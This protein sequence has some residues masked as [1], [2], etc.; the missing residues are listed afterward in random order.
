MLKIIS[1]TVL[2]SFIMASPV[3]AGEDKGFFESAWE[4]VTSYFSDGE[5][6]DKDKKDRHDKSDDH[7]KDDADDGVTPPAPTPAPDTTPPV[8]TP[9]AAVT[10]DSTT[11]K[12]IAVTIGT[13]TA[14]DANGNSATA[15][16]LVTVTD[17]SIFA[18]LPPDP[19][20]AGRATLA[21]IDSDNDGVRDDVQR[22]IVMT[23]PNSAKTRAALRQDAIALQ[24][25]I[26]DSANPTLT[27][28]HALED[29]KATDCL[30]YIR[31]NDFY[32]VVVDLEAVVVNTPQRSRAY[33]RADQLM[34]GK[35][36][37]SPPNRKQGC[38]FNPDVMPN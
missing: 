21:G 14:T 26:I 30:E 7:H 6:D 32:N 25:Y 37:S 22:W 13:A 38:N 36:F 9:S 11:G 10:A 5:D 34:S 20:A 1:M 3:H 19:G 8:I 16:Q 28:Q 27:Y 18:N 2:L 17:N 33:L 4:S 29:D 35:F 23:Y 12:P 24:K 31:P 15:T